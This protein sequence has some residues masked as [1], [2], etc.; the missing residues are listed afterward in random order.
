MDLTSRIANLSP[1]KRALLELAINAQESNDKS[2]AGAIIP[3][4]QQ[5]ATAPLSFAQQRLWFLDQLHPRKADYNLSHLLHIEG[6]LNIPALCDAL[7]VIVARHEALRTTFEDRRDEVFQRI[8]PELILEIP[9]VE[10]RDHTIQNN[11]LQSLVEEDVGRPFDLTADALLRAK[12]F[13]LAPDR[14]ILQ[15]TMHHIISDG[16]SIAVLNRELGILYNDFCSGSPPSLPQP[17]VQYLDYAVW[18]RQQGE[19]LQQQLEYWEQQLHDAPHIFELPIDKPRPAIQSFQGARRHIDLPP[20][21]CEALKALALRENA[22][23]FMVMLAAYQLL[24]HRYSGLDD[25]LVG[26]PIAGRTQPELEELIGFFVNS[27]VIRSRFSPELDFRQLLTR[28]RNATIGAFGHQELPFE[29][30][31]E[32]LTPQRDMSRNPIFQVMFSL[33]NDVPE[34]PHMEGLHVS[35]PDIG[36]AKA[37]F[38]LTLFVS[39]RA[40]G[41]RATFNYATDLFLDATIERMAGHY[42]TLLK[43]IVDNPERSIANLPLLSD[44][45]RTQLTQWNKTATEFPKT[46]GIQQ[47][48]EARAQATPQALAITD[49]HSQIS[50]GTLNRRA[51]QLA[52]YLIAQGTARG[53]L[54]G[55]CMERSIDAVMAMLAILKAGGA[56]V[57]LDPRHP[58]KR[59]ALI[60]EDAGLKTVICHKT[61]QALLPSHK[62]EQVIM[63]R[64]WQRIAILSEDNP[65]PAVNGDS[66]A[67]VIYTSGSTGRPK[68]VCIPHKAV[69]RLVTNTNYITLNA[70][71][72]IAQAANMS[73]DA[74][75]FEIWGALL[76][77]GRLYIIGIETLLSPP[78]FSHELRTAGITT[79]FLTTALFNQ[80]IRQDPAIFGDLKQLLFGGEVCDP[81]RIREC[82]R[83]GPP[84]RLLHAYGPTEATTFTTWYEVREIAP[85]ARTVPIGRPIANS[86]CHVLDAHR[87]PVPVG[88]IGELYI[89]GPGVAQGYLN[90]PELTVANFVGGPLGD[91]DR[92]YRSGDLVRY[93]ADGAIEFV[94]R[95]DNQIKLRG[96]RIETGEIDEVLK[97]HRSLRDCLTMLREDN[98][99]EKRLVSYVTTKPSEEIDEQTLRHFLRESLPEFMVPAAFVILDQLPLT[100]N[101]KVDRQALPA[102][103]SVTITVSGARPRN[104]LEFH[105]TK[106]WEDVLNRKPIGIHDNFFELGGHSLL[107]VR[108]FDQ[109]EK[110]FGEKLPLDTLWF[111]GATVATLTRILEK[112]QDTISWPELVEIKAGG[113]MLPLFCIHTMGGN[114]FHYYELARTLSPQL[115]VYGLQARG[116]YGKHSP[117]DNVAEIAADCINAMYLR[118]PHGPY[119]IAGFSSGGIVAFEMAQQLHAAGEKISTLAL[120]DCFAPGVKLK[121]SYGRWLRRLI[122]PSGLRQFQE[123]L[124]YRILQPLGLRHLRQIRTIGEAHRWAHWSYLPASYPDRIDLFV[125]AESGKKATDPLLGWSKIAGGD[126]MIHPVPGTHGLMVKSPHVEVLAEKLQDILNQ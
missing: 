91:G 45:E 60:I 107:A 126:L 77:G 47:L 35:S 79:L 89:G 119:R 36:T 40:E 125:A 100:P 18:Q 25:I 114:L 80:M 93:R 69:N 124:Y 81:Q 55:L 115:P 111:E 16:W 27:L 52:H 41:L 96:F 31:V 64:D 113:N 85:D 98:P 11:E 121:W 66:L 23:L 44:G 48:F 78:L 101:G 109:I 73:F 94:G 17:Q 46:A 118:Q 92:L 95:I 86:T 71:D 43:A 53:T 3:R 29:K 116:V 61:Q 62:L 68:G 5:R 63:D 15:I 74:A 104:A 82:L 56:Y 7:N 106:I 22:T 13:R 90:Q 99:G 49:N 70:D 6:P 76:N 120:L 54:V 37:K 88:V 72:V 34:L 87:Q 26:I 4:Q 24:L 112:E 1:A 10:L 50:Y 108:L 8:T 57:P 2:N 75:T 103:P 20:E 59:L 33:E 32:A 102:P 42:L 21:L 14:H 84:R 39:A 9:V 67:Y 38:D 97:K 51:N 105:L 12:L 110:H 83:G 19:V 122:T 28:I 117:R 30:L 123:R 65:A 58:K